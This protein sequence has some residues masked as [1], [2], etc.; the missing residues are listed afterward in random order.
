MQTIGAV[1]VAED[2]TGALRHDVT[3]LRSA[4]HICDAGVV[5]ETP[6]HCASRCVDIEAQKAPLL[7]RR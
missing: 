4:P 5:E 3:S 1:R 2:D 6:D 7:G